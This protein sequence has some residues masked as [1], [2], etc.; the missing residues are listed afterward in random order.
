VLVGPND[1]AVDVVQIPVEFT[2]ALGLCQQGSKDPLPD[3]LPI[4]TPETAVDR[5]PGAVA[6]RQVL[7]GSTGPRQPEDGIDDQ[8][9]IQG[10]PTGAR[11][12]GRQQRLDQLLLRIGEFTT[13]HQDP[14]DSRP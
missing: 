1:G 14:R 2:A 13:A 12:L 5:L 9:V 6:L 10:W 7:P 4:P 8:A 3:A 11:P